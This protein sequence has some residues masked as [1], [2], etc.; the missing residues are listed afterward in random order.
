MA[1]ILLDLSLL[2]GVLIATCFIENLYLIK[3]SKMS[4]FMLPCLKVWIQHGEWWYL[5]QGWPDPQQPNC[6]LCNASISSPARK[7]PIPSS[8]CLPRSFGLYLTALSGSGPAHFCLALLRSSPPP[9]PRLV[10]WLLLTCHAISSLLLHNC[11]DYIIN[12]WAVYVCGTVQCP[13]PEE[14]APL[15][16]RHVFI[17]IDLQELDWQS[18]SSIFSNLCIFFFPPPFKLCSR[19]PPTS[20]EAYQWFLNQENQS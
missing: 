3:K 10:F 18:R 4:R 1:E 6:G 7:H 2:S 15:S 5:E 8:R 12:Y 16:K 17:F 9:P 19:E 20:L 13:P 14:H 11:S